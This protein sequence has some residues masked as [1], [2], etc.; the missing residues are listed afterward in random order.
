MISANV[1]MF[2]LQHHQRIECN[3]QVEREDMKSAG[4]LNLNFGTCASLKCTY[5]NQRTR[6]KKKKINS[7]YDEC[8]T[9]DEELNLKQRMDNEFHLSIVFGRLFLA[10]EFH[11]FPFLNS[12]RKFVCESH[13]TTINTNIFFSSDFRL[14]TTTEREKK[15]HELQ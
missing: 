7:I 2:Y 14:S 6:E 11:S 8:R 12:S 9:E 13:E 5:N 3:S 1:L 15:K 10:N 4:I